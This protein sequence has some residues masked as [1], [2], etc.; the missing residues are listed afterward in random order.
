[1]LTFLFTR[2]PLNL[3]GTVFITIV[4]PGLLVLVRGCQC[5][6]TREIIALARSTNQLMQSIH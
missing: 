3:L 1:M 4:Y 2:V 5:F 6:F